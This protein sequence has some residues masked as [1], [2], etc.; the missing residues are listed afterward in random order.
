M[1]KFAAVLTAPDSNHR[2]HL[3]VNAVDEADARAQIAALEAQEVAFTLD[4]DIG[5]AWEQTDGGVLVK[6]GLGD[7]EYESVLKDYTFDDTGKVVYTGAG[8]GSARL[9]GKL[10][11]HNQTQP[12]TVESIELVDPDR[13]KVQWLLR[14]AT[15]LS[16]SRAELWAEA[17]Q[18]MKAQ[19]IPT[20]VVTAG[21]FGVPLKNMLGG[22]SVWDW[23]TTVQQCSLHTALTYDLDAHDFFNDV[24]ASEVTGTNYVANGFTLTCSAPTYDTASDQVRCDAGDAS[25]ATSTISA[26]D[27]AIWTN[28]GGA[29]TTDPLIAGIDFGATVSTTAGTFQ[30]TFDSTGIVVLDL[31]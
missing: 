4:D 29:S 1:P 31:T 11:Q 19:G 24:S 28:T 5:G 8:T 9:R 16:S 30:I 17:V 7:A 15:R 13:E 6:C 14:E 21:L 22:T 20:A 26:T 3:A 18:E 27:A 23:D 25:W 2:R 12:Y 10:A